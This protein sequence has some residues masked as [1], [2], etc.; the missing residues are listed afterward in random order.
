MEHIPIPKKMFKQM[1]KFFEN[2][3][4]SLV[5][6]NESRLDHIEL[7]DEDWLFDMLNSYLQDAKK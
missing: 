4:I 3:N 5:D 2:N 7:I 1:M 6:M